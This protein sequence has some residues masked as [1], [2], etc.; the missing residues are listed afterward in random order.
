MLLPTTGL[1]AL[2]SPLLLVALPTLGWRFLSHEP[3]Y[4]AS[5]GTT[6]PS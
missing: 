6:T 3:H 2:R 4:W 1:L 5:T